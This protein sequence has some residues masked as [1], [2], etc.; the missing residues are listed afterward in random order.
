MTTE[1]TAERLRELLSYDPE[2]GVFTWISGRLRTHK[3]GSLQCDG[4]TRIKIDGACLKAHRLA[5][6]Y[7]HGKWPAKHIDH[8]NG[9]RTDNRLCNLRECTDAE[10]SQ[11]RRRASKSSA[12]ELLGVARRVKRGKV[13]W[14][15]VISVGKES[16]WLGAFST[17]EQAHEV[18][19]QAKRKLHPFGML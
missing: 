8:I 14:Q 6:L 17:P 1:L 5:W 2:T 11:N 12:S 9:I 15:A 4:Y 13:R 16:R 18:Y 10:N 7:I 19:L 3:A